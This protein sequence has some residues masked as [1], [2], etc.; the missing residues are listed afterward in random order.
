MLLLALSPTQQTSPI[1]VSRKYRCESLWSI[2][3]ITPFSSIIFLFG[4][5]NII[6]CARG[7]SPGCFW[8]RQTRQCSMTKEIL[9]KI[10][11]VVFQAPQNPQGQ[12]PQPP[13]YDTLPVSFQELF[14]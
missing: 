2:A 13:K 10:Q 9:P 14:S 5:R 12:D 11:A 8:D 3:S 7:T 4:K 6:Y 1:T